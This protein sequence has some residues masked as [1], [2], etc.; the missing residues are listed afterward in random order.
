MK[1]IQEIHND[2]RK[3]DENPLEANTKTETKSKE[4]KN[5]QKKLE[6]HYPCF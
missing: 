3:G 1:K 5:C 4:I 6:K 2:G